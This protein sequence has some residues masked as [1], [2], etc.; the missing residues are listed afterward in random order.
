[1][2]VHGDREEDWDEYGDY[3]MP[4]G[5]DSG[6]SQCGTNVRLRAVSPGKQPIIW[7]TSFTATARRHRHR[8]ISLRDEMKKM[9][10]L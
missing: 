5:Y 2:D 4:V 9:G 10:L 8:P 7:L 6:D 3:T 1:M